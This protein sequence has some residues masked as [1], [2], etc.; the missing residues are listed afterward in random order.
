MDS[1]PSW[2]QANC[3]TKSMPTINSKDHT[4]IA[5]QKIGTGPGLVLVQGAMGSIRN[6]QQLSQALAGSF[7]VYLLERRGRGES[8]PVGSGYGLHTEVE[9]VQAMLKESGAPYLYGLSSGA[10]IS[11]ATA[12]V[13]PTVKKL[14]IYEP[15][16]YV[17]DPAK[18]AQVLANYRQ[19][20]SNGQIAK[21]MVIG[22]KGGQMGPAAFNVMPNWL[23]AGMFGKIMQAETANGDTKGYIAMEKLAPTLEQDFSLVVEVAA[24]IQQFK[25]VTCDT[26]LLGGSKS[27]QYLKVS[28]SAL[29]KILPHSTRYE[30]AG[31]GHSGSWDYD[32]Q[33]NASG[34]PTAVAEK[35]KSWFLA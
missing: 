30:F 17:N 2:H 33:R 23:L 20:M 29:E 15:P 26:L 16:L 11:L 12:A 31:L 35:L 3:Y 24:N 5:Y 21:A 9:D 4:K 1:N 7:T 19:A 27:P 32:K 28:L 6:Y 10:I 18:P 34:N 13:T 14:A 22:M 8:C 25:S